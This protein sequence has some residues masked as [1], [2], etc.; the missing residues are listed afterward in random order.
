VSSA[1]DPSHAEGHLGINNQQEMECK[2]CSETPTWAQEA[3]MF[4]VVEEWFHFVVRRHFHGNLKPPFNEHAR[5]QAG[6]DKSWYMP[7]AS[8]EI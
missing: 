3:L 2:E 1:N 7:L 4:K 8:D 5:E 6:F